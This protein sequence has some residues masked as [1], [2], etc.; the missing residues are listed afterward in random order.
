MKILLLILTLLLFSQATVA[1]SRKSLLKVGYERIEA[2]QSSRESVRERMGKPDFT[3]DF[4]SMNTSIDFWCHFP[5]FMARQ[6]RYYVIYHYPD[7]DVHS[8]TKDADPYAEPER[9]NC[10]SFISYL[11]EKFELYGYSGFGH[12]E[13][14]ARGLKLPVRRGGYADFFSTS[15][16]KEDVRLYYF[17]GAFDSSVNRWNSSADP[18]KC[19]ARQKYFPELKKEVIS[20]ASFDKPV[21]IF[22]EVNRPTSTDFCSRY[23]GTRNHGD[24]V[25]ELVESNWSDVIREMKAAVAETEIKDDCRFDCAKSEGSPVQQQGSKRALPPELNVVS[26]GTGFFVSKMGHIVTN[27]HVVEQCEAIQFTNLGTE[28]SAVLLA[29]DKVNDVALLKAEIEPA[30][31][32][33]IGE[34]KAELLQRIFV[35]GFPFGSVVSSSLK[36][37]SGIVSSLAG[38]ND[39]YSN[40]QIDAALQKGNSGGPIVNEKGNVVGIAVGKLNTQFFLSRYGSIPEGSNFGIKGTIAGNLL[41]ANQVKVVPANQEKLQTSDLSNSLV[42]ATINLRCLGVVEVREKRQKGS[43]NTQEKIL[44]L[45]IRTIS[46]QKAKELGIDTG[47]E[48]FRVANVAKSIGLVSGDVILRIRGQKIGGVEDFKEV[49]TFIKPGEFIPIKVQRQRRSLYLSWKVP[50]LP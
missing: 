25:L 32:L 26:T 9:G 36:V 7:G 50:A 14:H 35:A 16:T 1:E 29:R 34:E 40:I 31:V 33:H 41:E 21:F 39:N 18:F 45:T 6:R 15:P 27:N 10:D 3:R 17:T 19:D 23:L 43:S 38:I 48:V 47:V 44:G 4:P 46:S 8:K 5:H 12:L 42:Q 24:G 22:K 13:R 30:G 28:V 20:A 37:T 49:V 11:N 2:G